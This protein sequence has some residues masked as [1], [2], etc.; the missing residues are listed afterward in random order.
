[1]DV[2]NLPLNT[3]ILFQ[4]NVIYLF[5]LKY[6]ILLKNGYIGDV[7]KYAIYKNINFSP[8]QQLNSD[9]VKNSGYDD[10]FKI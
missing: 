4:T 9:T 10:I 5:I 6:A 1:M 8:A 3:Q 2:L 7:A